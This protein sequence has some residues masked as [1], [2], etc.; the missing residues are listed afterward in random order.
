[1]SY[2]YWLDDPTSWFDEM[3]KV[4]NWCTSLPLLYLYPRF[5]KSPVFSAVRLP[6]F[7]RTQSP[8]SNLHIFFDD[9]EILLVSCNSYLLLYFN[10]SHDLLYVPNDFFIYQICTGL[11]CVYVQ[12]THDIYSTSLQIWSVFLIVK[13]RVKVEG[14]VTH[15]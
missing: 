8:L 7:I 4:T 15:S 9:D 11:C 10:L 6:I 5:W 3:I 2:I 12:S 14:R 13:T 1:M